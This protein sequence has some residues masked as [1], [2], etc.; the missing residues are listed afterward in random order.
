LVKAARAEA[1]EGSER[2][3]IVTRTKGSPEDMIRF[4][5]GPGAIV[6]PDIRRKLPGRGVYVTAHADKISEAVRRQ[7]FARGFKAK[8]TAPEALSAQI[9]DLLT[10]DCLQT[11]SI[12]NKAGQ[13]VAGF[14]KVE[15]EIASGAIAGLIH[16]SD[17]GA[18]GIRKLT[19]TLH[20]RFGADGMKPQI[21]LF[22]SA[23]LD[24]ALGRANVIHAALK[25]GAASDAFLK[26][27]RRL[28]LY[29]SGVPQEQ[30]SGLSVDEGL[31]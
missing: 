27:C 24:L 1:E 10:K 9:E 3:C 23:Q 29:R 30:N 5:V 26:R 12:V 25:A 31:D 21:K 8:V 15:D 22:E 17:A 20:R 18:D 11:L 13:V 2:T 19:Q 4:V 14:G 28:S 16:A 6:V 7:A